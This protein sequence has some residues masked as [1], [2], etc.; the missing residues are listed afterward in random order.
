M[1]NSRKRIEWVDMSKGAAILLVIVGHT[2]GN[3]LLR[4]LIFSF[5]MPLFFILSGYTSRCPDNKT[6]LWAKTK[7]GLQHLI[8]PAYIIYIVRMIL[9]IILKDKE[10][11]VIECSLSMVFVSGYRTSFSGMEIPEFGMMWFLVVLFG[12]KFLYETI[13]MLTKNRYMFIISVVVSTSGVIIGRIMFLPLSFDLI[14]SSMLF[15]NIGQELKAFDLNDKYLLKLI[16]S[17]V[18]W[19]GMFVLIFVS[20]D[21]YLEMATRKYPMYPL[22][23]VMAAAGSL[24]VCLIMMKLEKISIVTKAFGWVGKNSIYL[25]IVHAFDTLWLDMLKKISDDPPVLAIIRT[26]VDVI[27]LI[28]YVGIIKQINQKE[29]EIK[30]E[31]KI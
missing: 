17:G 15:F 14:M 16:A 5:H 8:V 10:T 31:K 1:S 13:S 6:A 9:L 21:S 12:M 26:A 30:N 23:Y 28:V 18:V 11:N 19:T 3:P 27:L 20:A 4:G 24:T 29:P 7:N 25:F 2:I 22:C